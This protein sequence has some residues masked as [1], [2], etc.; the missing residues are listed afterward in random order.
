MVLLNAQT[1]PIAT[2]QYLHIEGGDGV[3]KKIIERG[4][5]NSGGY[6]DVD[7]LLFDASVGAEPE[8]EISPVRVTVKRGPRQPHRPY[9]LKAGTLHRGSGNL[10]NAEFRIAFTL[11]F[12]PKGTPP[13]SRE[14][15]WETDEVD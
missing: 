7:K 9:I 5:A 2:T 12:V 14:A 6:V 10:L 4:S 1:D 8:S 3:E 11:S 13:S 15:I